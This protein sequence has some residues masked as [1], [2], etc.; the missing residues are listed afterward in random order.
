MV[1]LGEEER[2]PKNLEN[3]QILLLA[4]TIMVYLLFLL[5][6]IQKKYIFA[7]NLNSGHSH[8]VH[9]LTVKS[10]HTHTHTHARTLARSQARTHARTHAHT[11]THTHT[12]IFSRNETKP[13][14]NENI[15]AKRD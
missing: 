15:T 8:V 1:K 7:S 11:H 9:Y 6:S 4:C 3:V 5:A 14:G 10:T 2:W 13:F 12:Q